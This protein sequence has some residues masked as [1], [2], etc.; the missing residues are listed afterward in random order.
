[1]NSPS[2]HGG[3]HTPQPDLDADTAEAVLTGAL[4]SGDP[5]LDAT[6][7]ALRALVTTAPEPTGELARLLG[8]TV[9]PVSGDELGRRRQGSARHVATGTTVVAGILLATATAAAAIGTIGGREHA[10]H[11]APPPAVVSPPRATTP[12]PVA[13]TPTR[14]PVLAVASHEATHAASDP[15]TTR[16]HAKLGPVT[17]PTVHQHGD[18]SDHPSRANEPGDAKDGAG[19]GDDQASSTSRGTSTGGDGT[20]SGTSTGGQEAGDTAGASHD[21]SGSGPGS[22]PGSGSDGASGSDSVTP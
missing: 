1:M 14:L 22:G 2:Q 6:L 7:E 12:H 10:G 21:G 18:D 20:S 16:P 3:Q 19:R 8:P 15:S 5:A 13:T 11:A 9:S 17:V 4:P